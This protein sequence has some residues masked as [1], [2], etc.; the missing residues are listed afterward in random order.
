MKSANALLHGRR[1]CVSPYDCERY[2]R[3]CSS[4]PRDK[5][6]IRETLLILEKLFLS[7]KCLLDFFA[8]ETQFFRSEQKATVELRNQE[9]DWLESTLSGLPKEK[10]KTIFQHVP[11]FI[12]DANETDSEWRAIPMESRKNLMKIYW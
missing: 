11:L 1:C 12:V 6:P 10:A 3:H 8:L 5:V 7:I 9:L 4:N 2:P